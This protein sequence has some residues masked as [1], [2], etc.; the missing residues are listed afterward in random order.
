[1]VEGRAQVGSSDSDVALRAQ[2]ETVD[3]KARVVLLH[4]RQQDI[5]LRSDPLMYN[6]LTSP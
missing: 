3:W 4:E 1:M 5:E 2:A 6:P